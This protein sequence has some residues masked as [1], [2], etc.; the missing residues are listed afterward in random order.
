MNDINLT[1]TIDEANLILEGLGHLPFGKVFALVA[2][3][4]EQASLQ[5]NSEDQSGAE[6]SSP[7]P[8]V[9]D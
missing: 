1:V 4:Q 6:A 3:V 9:K 7:P 8:T 2:K 5:L